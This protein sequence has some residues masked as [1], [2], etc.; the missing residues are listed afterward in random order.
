MWKA[1]LIPVAMGF[2][3][4]AAV[5]LKAEIEERMRERKKAKQLTVLLEKAKRRQRD[6]NNDSE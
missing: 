4:W 3:T 1:A 5:L 6:S 2:I